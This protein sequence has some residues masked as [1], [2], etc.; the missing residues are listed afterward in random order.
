M[1]VTWQFPLKTVSE[2]NCAEHWTKKSKRHR[3]QKKI[4]QLIWNTSDD[5]IHLP[6]H[7]TLT[8]LA[9]R[10]LDYDNLVC[11]MKWVLDSI[12]DLLV[13]GLRPGRADGDKRITV[14]YKQDKAKSMGIRIEFDFDI[15]IERSCT[16]DEDKR[17]H[18]LE[19]F[20]LSL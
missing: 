12:C 13:P 8:R 7:I 19:S 6:C 4:I 20:G 2:M 1:K 9:T 18:I 14:D 10:E 16:F 17:S 5:D 11:S 3:M 15:P